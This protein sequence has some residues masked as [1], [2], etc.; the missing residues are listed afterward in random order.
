LNG[1]NSS[2]NETQF[3]KS[4]FAILEK[5][6]K[7]RNWIKLLFLPSVAKRLPELSNE[8]S[9]PKS[10]SSF[11]NILSYMEN[12]KIYLYFYEGRVHYVDKRYNESIVI[13]HS[14]F[15]DL[16]NDYMATRDFHSFDGKTKEFTKFK[17][18]SS[19]S[20]VNKSL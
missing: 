15:L 5:L 14:V 19:K 18:L 7:L 12:S 11:D 4:R 6:H 2:G 3:S 8:P 1:N 20:S 9:I 16:I 17:I 13:P 10:K